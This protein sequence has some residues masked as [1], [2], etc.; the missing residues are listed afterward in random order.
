MSDQRERSTSTERQLILAGGPAARGAPYQKSGPSEA[1]VPLCRAGNCIDSSVATHPIR[2]ARVVNRRGESSD[3]HEPSGAA[4]TSG[5]S[6]EGVRGDGSGEAMR[7]VRTVRIL[8]SA[9]QKNAMNRTFPVR[10]LYGVVE[11]CPIQLSK[12][13]LSCDY[14]D[15]PGWRQQLELCDSSLMRAVLLRWPARTEWLRTRGPKWPASI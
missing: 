15:A 3:C 14:E 10:P 8:V 7:L 5:C 11:E 6:G 2:V 9:H 1:R 12:Q 13:D 4:G